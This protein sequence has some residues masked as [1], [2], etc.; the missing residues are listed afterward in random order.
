MEHRAAEQELSGTVS[1]DKNEILFSRFGINYNKEPEVFKK[2]TVMYRDVGGPVR[3]R[4]Y[5][6]R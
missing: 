1:A 6:H 2:G 5:F 4:S 3:H